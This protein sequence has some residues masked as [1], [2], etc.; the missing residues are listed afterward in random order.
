[1][2]SDSAETGEEPLR[3]PHFI[4]QRSCGYRGRRS[5]SRQA[6]SLQGWF[7][8][9]NR[10]CG[11]RSRGPRSVS[12]TGRAQVRPHSRLW[13][14][15]SENMFERFSSECKAGAKS[16]THGVL[17]GL[18]TH[19]RSC[20]IDVLLNLRTV[21]SH[22]HHAI[23]DSGQQQDTSTILSASG[24]M[25]PETAKTSTLW[26]PSKGTRPWW[27]KPPWTRSTSD[28][29]PSSAA[30]VRALLVPAPTVFSLGQVC[31]CTHAVSRGRA[32]D[33]DP[34]DRAGAERP[35]RFVLRIP[36]PHTVR[37]DSARRQGEG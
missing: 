12:T 20:W 25:L 35:V 29:G 27:R 14:C 16:C 6:G 1:M 13:S 24:A 2:F 36:E 4:S 15:S 17:S 33:C 31:A 18:L 34:R 8:R 9:R 23:V 19:G 32:S 5:R 3:S 7:R 28:P 11:S 26:A 22:V 30:A 10:G 21:V 37:E